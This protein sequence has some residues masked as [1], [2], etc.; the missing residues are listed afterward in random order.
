MATIQTSSVHSQSK[1]RLT[2]GSNRD[3]S[4]LVKEGY[5]H[6][7]S[8]KTLIDLWLWKLLWRTKMPPK[9]ICF[10]WRKES[11]AK[12]TRK[13]KLHEL[14]REHGKVPEGYPWRTRLNATLVRA[15][16]RD[17]F[18]DFANHCDLSDTT[19]LCSEEKQLSECSVDLLEISIDM[20]PGGVRPKDQP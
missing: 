13:Q 16:V 1:D 18:A 19:V 15:R 12:P 20:V 11:T 4:Y 9:V 2:W 3:G 7:S 6:L 5:L 10:S 14:H 8:R 17:S